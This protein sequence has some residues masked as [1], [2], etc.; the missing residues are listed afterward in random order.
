MIEPQSTSHL[1]SELLPVLQ[2]F[3][4][5]L[6]YRFL[7]DYLRQSFWSVK[8]MNEIVAT[9]PLSSQR[10]KDE[11]LHNT[12]HTLTFFTKATLQDA[13]FRPDFSLNLLTGENF[14]LGPFRYLDQLNWQYK[15]STD[16]LFKRFLVPADESQLHCMRSN[17]LLRSHRHNAQSIC[18]VVFTS[19]GEHVWDQ[20]AK[21]LK[22]FLS[23][24]FCI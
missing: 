7:L 8:Q 24:A 10:Q 12:R 13:D 20:R 22:L 17:G 15:G 6:V 23:C 3:N 18:T 21:H 1:I 11:S 19:Y 14:L 16:R 4:D 2:S 9:Q 5:A